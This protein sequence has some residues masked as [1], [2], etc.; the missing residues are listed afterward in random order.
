MAQRGRPRHPGLLTQREE[1]V[2]ALLRADLTNEQIAAR[3]GISFETA[4]HHVSQVLSKLGVATR[5]EAA[6]WRPEREAQRWTPSR[7]AIVIG[8]TSVLAAT[9]AGL[10]LL[11]WGVSETEMEARPCRWEFQ[12]QLKLALNCWSLPPCRMIRA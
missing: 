2:L 3:L 1:D 12:A 9:V 5:E 10:A 4:K 7:I 6:A 11:A 8:S